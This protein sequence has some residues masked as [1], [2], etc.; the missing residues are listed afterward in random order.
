M[1]RLI[2]FIGALVLA[3][4]GCAKP[5]EFTT[6]MRDEMGPEA[7][8]VAALK[9]AVLEAFELRTPGR[10]TIVVKNWTQA[11]AAK[12]PNDTTIVLDVAGALVTGGSDT[13]SLTFAR[14]TSRGGSYTLRQ[15]NGAWIGSPIPI[16]TITYQYHPCYQNVGSKC[17]AAVPTGTREDQ[18]V[19]VG[20]I[21]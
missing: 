10:A 4:S 11:L 3:L 17:E 9:L 14:S 1:Q 19:R 20:I 6:A 8:N 16:G 7:G 5:V 18:S 21:R 12:A 15:I 2:P 13:L